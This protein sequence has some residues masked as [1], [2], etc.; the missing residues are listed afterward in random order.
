M[1]GRL[2]DV[3]NPKPSVSL[4]T[5]RRRAPYKAAKRVKLSCLATGSVPTTLIRLSELENRRVET[6]TSVFATSTIL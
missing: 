2:E 1:E 6:F 3:D 4:K 5:E